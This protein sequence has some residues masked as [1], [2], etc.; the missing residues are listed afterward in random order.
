MAFLQT[1]A[2]R[3]WSGKPAILACLTSTRIAAESVPDTKTPS[4]PSQWVRAD[5]VA[6]LLL[7]LVENTA[8][9]KVAVGRSNR[10]QSAG[11]CSQS[12]GPIHEES[13][14]G[15]WSGRRR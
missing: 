3:C 1:R 10:H 8:E 15:A 4:R 12:A 14:A 9:K 5:V 2:T 7:R 13:E 11:L 6:D